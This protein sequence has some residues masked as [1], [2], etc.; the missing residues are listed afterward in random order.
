MIQ[1]KKPLPE[2]IS[3]FIY[4]KV[5]PLALIGAGLTGGGYICFKNHRLENAIVQESEPDCGND[6]YYGEFCWE[7]IEVNNHWKCLYLK[8]G[9][10]EPSTK[11]EYVKWERGFRLPLL[12]CDMILEY[13]ISNEEKIY[14]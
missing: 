8:N 7:E 9:N 3:N 10:L 14:K 11:L 2:R 13:K 1:M 5:V 4:N 6:E 12:E